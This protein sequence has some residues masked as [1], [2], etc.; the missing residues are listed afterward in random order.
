MIAN[1]ITGI[2]IVCA[3]ALIFCPTFSDGF[4]ALYILGG[5][6]DVLD[7]IVARRLGKETGLGARLD[8][9]ADT[10]FTATVLIKVVRAIH[11]PAWLLLW[12]GCIAVIKGVNV[13]SGFVREKRFIPE[14][15]VMNKV[16]GVLL[17]AVPL[18]IG[19]L[20]WQTAKIPIIFAGVAATVAALQEGQYIRT[21]KEIG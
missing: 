8:T 6:S 4:Y 17:F 14:H 3:L 2:R 21:G 12:T 5:I 15:T 11:F 19:I 16:C 18:C 10:V 13:I 20:P 1:S 9:A 7:G